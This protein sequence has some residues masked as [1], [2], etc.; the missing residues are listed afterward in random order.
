MKH[1]STCVD[2]RKVLKVTA[3]RISNYDPNIASR[4]MPNKYMT[5]DQRN[6]KFEGIQRERESLLK[7]R[8]SVET[9]IENLILREGVAIDEETILGIPGKVLKK[10]P[11][12][13]DEN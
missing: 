7:N 5:T 9:K 3:T 12:G 2:Y 6:L 8:N 13:F 10:E 1:C 11:V 4:N